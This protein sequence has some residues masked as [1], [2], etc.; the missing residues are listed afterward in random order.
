[1]SIVIISLVLI[2]SLS[3]FIIILCLLLS[4]SQL[5]SSRIKP[6][7]S[8]GCPADPWNLMSCM[9][10]E[11]TY[12]CLYVPLCGHVPLLQATPLDNP[13]LAW[14]NG[15]WRVASWWYKWTC[16]SI[17]YAINHWRNETCGRLPCPP[18]RSVYF[19]SQLALARDIFTFV[20]S[21]S[22]SRLWFLPQ[23]WFYPVSWVGTGESTRC[24]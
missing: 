17:W 22:L 18:S 11:R 3:F 16:T 20:N 4:H 23:F 10:R 1:M 9:P 5:M 24:R 14:N 12:S 13:A 21:P 15:E 2:L 8:V 19:Q 7:T 6:C